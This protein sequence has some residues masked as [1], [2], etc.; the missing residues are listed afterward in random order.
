[1][2]DWPAPPLAPTL[3]R[4]WEIAAAELRVNGGGSRPSRAPLVAAP[5]PVLQYEGGKRTGSH[6]KMMRDETGA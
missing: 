6:A 1:V 3:G 4:K 5:L 2:L